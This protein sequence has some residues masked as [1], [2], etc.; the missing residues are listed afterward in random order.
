MFLLNPHLSVHE[1]NF[2]LRNVE[3]PYNYELCEA[4]LGRISPD[5]LLDEV[6]KEYYELKHWADFKKS[7]IKQEQI[8]NRK[9]NKKTKLAEN[10][11]KLH[12][13]GKIPE[14]TLLLYGISGDLPEESVYK[15]MTIEEKENFWNQRNRQNFGDISNPYS[16][17]HFMEKQNKKPAEKI[18][19][20][21]QGF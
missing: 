9:K 2:H 13:Q 3:N 11:I 17:N 4:I 21:C 12:R 10:M 7:K 16:F 14:E 20:I 6:K 19:W 15:N 5:D 1:Q 18:D 8:N